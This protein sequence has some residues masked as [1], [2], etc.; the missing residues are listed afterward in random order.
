M[1]IKITAIVAIIM[2]TLVACNSSEQENQKDTFTEHLSEEETAIPDFAESDEVEEGVYTAEAFLEGPDQWFYIADRGTMSG[3]EEEVPEEFDVLHVVPYD[4]ENDD[5]EIVEYMMAVADVDFQLYDDFERFTGKVMVYYNGDKSILASEF[6]VFNGKPNGKCVVY[7]PDGSVFIDRTYEHGEWIESDTEPYGVDWTF[8]QYISSLSISDENR[9]ITTED[10]IKVV[11]IMRSIHADDGKD[12]NLYRIMEKKSFQNPF[13]VN[14]EYF[15]GILKAYFHPKGPE[16]ELYYELPFKDG[17]LNGEVKI[18]ND[19]GELELHELFTMGELD[20]VLYQL[21]YGDGIA[22]P[23][24]YLYPEKDMIVNVELDFNG[25]LTHTYPKYD[26]G[27][28]VYAKS[29]GTLYDKDGNEYYA[30]Y[31]EGHE[32]EP[33][34]ID[35]GFVI[36]GAKTTEFLEDALATLGL[37]RREANEFIIYWLPQMEN[38]PYNLIHFSTEQYEEMAELKIMPEPETVIRV[39]MVFQPLTDIIEIP[40]QDLSKMKKK[41]NGFTVVEWGGK[42]LDKDDDLGIE[43]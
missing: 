25:R 28:M 5:N 7:N 4:A 9:A 13:K 8:Y 29:D 40:K 17:W 1:K 36:E 18:Y 15:T 19:W 38:N 37:N 10:G 21:E 31:W 23:V 41:R 43:L 34:K 26:K 14:E 27:W 42:K 16:A 33:F 35:E 12:N 2:S 3:G 32:K 11:K 20:T 6:D 24:I 30:L 22:K 39:M